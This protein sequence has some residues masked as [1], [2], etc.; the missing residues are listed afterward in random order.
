MKR[1]FIAFAVMAALATVATAQLFRPRV[2]Q[3]GGTACGPNGC[4][5]Q[6]VQTTIVPASES[7]PTG[8]VE[9][10]KGLPPIEKKTEPPAEAEE[11]AV[12]QVE[13][14]LD[15]A[16]D[17]NF[18]VLRDM[19]VPGRITHNGREITMGEAMGA[20]VGQIP[21]ESKK[22][23]LTVI[24]S[25]AERKS[26]MDGFAQ[27]EPALKE[28]IAPWSVPP[29]HWS[30]KDQVSGQ[31]VFKTDGHPTVYLQAPDGKALHR[32]DDFKG[33]GDFEAI[34]KAVKA[35]DASKDPDLLKT[36]DRAT[37]S[38]IPTPALVVGG[39]IALAFLVRRK[40]Q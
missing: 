18:G 34:R 20:L 21:D 5:P 35:Y 30:L 9:P 36:P 7:L 8:V 38:S 33:P 37:L 27:L 29:D 15:P 22:F 19:I 3:W 23:R 16:T 32:R 17:E 11:K 10:K 31:T 4:F 24:G 12:G 6:Q 1:F 25:H 13:P 39:M 28:R 40:Q 26:V 14:K 2:I